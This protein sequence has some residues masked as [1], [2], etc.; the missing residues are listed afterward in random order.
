MGGVGNCGGLLSSWA[1]SSVAGPLSIDWSARHV[2]KM[3]PM[4][5][6]DETEGG[7]EGGEAKNA[8]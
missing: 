6:G 3:F 8:A 1:F 4:A 2:E 5:C 7:L